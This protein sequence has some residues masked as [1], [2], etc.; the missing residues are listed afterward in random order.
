SQSGRI[1]QNTLT[2]SWVADPRTETST[3][4]FDA[5]GRLTEAV[6]PITTGYCYDAS[7]RLLSTAVAGAPAGANT[8][9]STK[10]W[11]V[12]RRRLKVWSQRRN[13]T[14]IRWSSFIG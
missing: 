11:H 9:L 5:A 13:V 1:M 4:T 7:D 12:V 10:R 14:V 2:D 8:L 3:Y 6:I